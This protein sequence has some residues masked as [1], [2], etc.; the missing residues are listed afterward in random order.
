MKHHVEPGRKLFLSQRSLSPSDYIQTKGSVG[1]NMSLMLL[2]HS[3]KGLI[4]FHCFIGNN[5][6]T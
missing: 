3:K 6:I 4:I 5:I 1:A 2:Y